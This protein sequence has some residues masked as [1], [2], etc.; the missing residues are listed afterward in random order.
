[1][2]KTTIDNSIKLIKS[3]VDYNVDDFWA[4]FNIKEEIDKQRDVLVE[5]FRSMQDVIF[6][7]ERQVHVLQ[8]T[9][10]KNSSRSSGTRTRSR[11]K[12]TQSCNCRKTIDMNRI[13]RE[14][15]CELANE[16]VGRRGV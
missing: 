14:I 1:M 11:C 6:D 3:A 2:S 7:L 10:S 8:G 16:S 4:S 5:Y 13:L 9:Q 12:S 15:E